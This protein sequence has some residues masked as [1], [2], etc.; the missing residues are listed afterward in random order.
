MLNTVAC[1]F[2][3][4]LKLFSLRL[5]TFIGLLICKKPMHLLLKFELKVSN[6][7]F[8]LKANKT[9]PN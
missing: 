1:N 6:F 5:V 7:I 9:S 8:H 4:T 2:K 3:I